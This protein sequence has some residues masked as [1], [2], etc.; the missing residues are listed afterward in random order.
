MIAQIPA[1]INI[2]PRGHGGFEQPLGGVSVRRRRY[3]EARY[4]EEELLPL[5]KGCCS[6]CPRCA[7]LDKEP[8]RNPDEALSS[9]EAYGMNVIALQKSAGLPY[10]GGKNT[11]LY[12][13]LILFDKSCT[14]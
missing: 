10:Y 14:G 4:P 5:D 12:V 7:Y 2:G 13:G 1:H 11:V 9:I 8:C 3:D 6:I